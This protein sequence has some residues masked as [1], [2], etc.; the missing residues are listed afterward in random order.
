MPMNDSF[1]GRDTDFTDAT[2]FTDLVRLFNTIRS[3]LESA[4][5]TNPA[6]KRLTS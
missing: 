2:D 3:G 4:E 6:K 5:R 1:L